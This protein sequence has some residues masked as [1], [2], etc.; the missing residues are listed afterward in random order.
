MHTARAH[1]TQGGSC[2]SVLKRGS[3]SLSRCSSSASS[4]VC[5]GVTSGGREQRSVSRLRF[6]F[7]LSPRQALLCRLHF[8]HSAWKKFLLRDVTSV[9]LTS[10][11]APRP[12]E[13]L[14]LRP[15]FPRRGGLSS[16]PVPS[17]LPL[18]CVNATFDSAAFFLSFFFFAIFRRAF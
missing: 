1:A 16:Q 6:R 11:G 15:P 4:V 2:V 18:L 14:P 17:C 5:S 9:I 7:F 12:N 8:A 10:D 13:G 3:V